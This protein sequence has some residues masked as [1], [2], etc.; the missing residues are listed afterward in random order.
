[1]GWRSSYVSRNEAVD[2]ADSPAP[3]PAAP[4]PG[5][6]GMGGMY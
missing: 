6:G 2:V 3:E 5:A 1:M 4:A